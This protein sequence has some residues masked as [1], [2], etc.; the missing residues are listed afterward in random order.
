MKV[1]GAAFTG[2]APDITPEGAA[3]ITRHIECDSSRAVAELGYRFT[4]PRVLLE[5]TCAWMREVGLLS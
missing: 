2:R 1:L 4:E 5:E 3:M